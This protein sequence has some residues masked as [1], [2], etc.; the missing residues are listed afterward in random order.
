MVKTILGCLLSKEPL[1]PR[2]THDQAPN[3]L[4]FT[5]NYE[6]NEGKTIFME[7]EDFWVEYIVNLL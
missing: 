6:I 1:L 5:Y 7:L 4:K 2:L 3:P